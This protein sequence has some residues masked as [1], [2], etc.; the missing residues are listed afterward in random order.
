[1][2]ASKAFHITGAQ[3]LLLRGEAFN[4][5]NLASYAAPVNTLSSSLGATFGR[6]TATNSSQRIMQVSLHYQF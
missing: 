2:A 6:I 1:L 5:L 3:T 4:A